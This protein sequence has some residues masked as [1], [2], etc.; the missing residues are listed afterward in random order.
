MLF[1]SDR[2][3]ANWR[4]IRGF[5]DNCDHAIVS[6]VLNPDAAGKIYNVGEPVAFTEM[7][8][9]ENLAA[10]MRWSGKIV[11]IP[12]DHLPDYLR[13]PLDWNANLDIATHRIRKDLGFREIVGY[14]DGL[15]RTIEWELSHPPQPVGTALKTADAFDYGLEDRVLKR[16]LRT[17]SLRPHLDDPRQL[18]LRWF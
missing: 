7:E 10:M 5:R 12:S 16:V 3:Q 4:G 9:I 13:A 14:D 18:R 17:R 15:Q 11:A 1:R 8:W 6:A 2:T